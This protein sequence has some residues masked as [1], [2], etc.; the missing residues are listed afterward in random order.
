MSSNESIWFA[1]LFAA[2]LIWFALAH[3]LFQLLRENHREIYES[4]GSPSLLLNN[5][6]RSNWLGLK[7]LFTGSFR[8]VNDRRIT[9]LCRFMRV[10]LVLCYLWLLGPLAWVLLQAWL[11]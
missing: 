4:L 11:D 3:R 6:V 2:M 10:Y 8:S 5:T 1:V 9:R 7:F